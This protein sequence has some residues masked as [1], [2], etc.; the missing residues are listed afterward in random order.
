MI[1]GKT[2]V[3]MAQLAMFAVGLPLAA[4]TV[5]LPL[6]IVAWV[7]A[8]ITGVQLLSEARE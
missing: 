8:M 4:F 6:M 3:G 5:G 7:W 2:G 1:G